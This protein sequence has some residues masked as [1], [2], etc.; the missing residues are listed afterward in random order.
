MRGTKYL[1]SKFGD[2]RSSLSR[3]I[4]VK[5]FIWLNSQSW[6]LWPWKWQ[7]D[8][9]TI[10]SNFNIRGTCTPNLVILPHLLLELLW[11]Y[12]LY[13]EIHKVD[14]C[15][16][17]N[18]SW[19]PIYNSKQVFHERYL[20]TKLGDPSWFTSQIMAI[21]RVDRRKDGQTTLWQ[22]P[23]TKVWQKVKTKLF[24]RF[25]LASILWL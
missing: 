3:V 24:D 12:R 4:V 25:L 16:L 18:G 8:P 9:Y 23:S 5:S 13:D 19:W 14:L 2:P 21:T 22:Y 20:H 17:G 15:D 6:P 1:N 11:Y 7:G 10:P